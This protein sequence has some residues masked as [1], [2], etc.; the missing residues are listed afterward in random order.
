M[1]DLQVTLTI[2]ARDLYDIAQMA[3]DSLEDSFGYDVMEAAGVE[4]QEVFDALLKDKT[5]QSMVMEKVK[6]DGMYVTQ[7][8]YDYFDGYDFLDNVPGLIEIVKCCKA[9]DAIVADAKKEPEVSC[10][11]VP[12]GYKLVKI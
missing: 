7:D 6:E 1:N 5:F 11:P 4:D 2:R 9:M 8:P 3:I 12:A 10:I